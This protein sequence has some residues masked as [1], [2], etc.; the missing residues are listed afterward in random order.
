MN[1]ETKDVL[2][3]MVNLSGLIE[4]ALVAHARRQSEITEKLKLFGGE[5][6]GRVWQGSNYPIEAIREPLLEAE[7]MLTQIYGLD[8]AD[9]EALAAISSSPFLTGLGERYGEALRLAAI[10]RRCWRMNASWSYVDLVEYSPLIDR[11]DT[12]ILFL[13]VRLPLGKPHKGHRVEAE[14]HNLSGYHLHYA[15]LDGMRSDILFAFGSNPPEPEF[16]VKWERH[17]SGKARY[18]PQPETWN[19][20]KRLNV[21]QVCLAARNKL[22]SDARFF[23]PGK[24]SLF[25]LPMI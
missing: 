19:R 12:P 13:V 5:K 1:T 25:L 11:S 7:R 18:F 15:R 20:K 17:G 10:E 9:E 3:R 24:E 4:T 2:G 23:I 8:G 21:N 16:P 6:E 14:E 22:P